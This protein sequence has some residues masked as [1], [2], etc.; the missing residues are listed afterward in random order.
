MRA[1]RI[2]RGAGRFQGCWHR[3]TC[4]AV[5]AL[6]TSMAFGC[7]RQS[8]LHAVSSRRVTGSATSRGTTTRGTRKDKGLPLRLEPPLTLPRL[9]SARLRQLHSP[10]MSSLVWSLPLPLIRAP[11]RHGLRG[12]GTSTRT[13]VAAASF[14]S[15]TSVAVTSA[16]V[17]TPT[18]VALPAPVGRFR[19]PQL[20]KVLLRGPPVRQPAATSSA[21]PRTSRASSSSTAARRRMGPAL[22]SFSHRRCTLTKTKRTAR[23][24]A[25][26]RSRI[27]CHGDT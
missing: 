21:W 13:S 24:L 17:T 22:R 14:A 4:A 23:A 11:C 6:H 19:R 12:A 18:T 2:V 16:G 20:D 5:A 10:L 9:D 8:V 7:T 25:A 3:G 26:A 1:G 15:V 27:S